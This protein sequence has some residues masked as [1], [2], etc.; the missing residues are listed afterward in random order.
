VG[1]FDPASEAIT[2]HLGGDVAESLHF[3][4][5][6]SVLTAA[7]RSGLHLLTLFA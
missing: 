6:G 2:T 4:P 3:S 1:Q 7:G 5:D